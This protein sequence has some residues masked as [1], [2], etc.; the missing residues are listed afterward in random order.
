MPYHPHTSGQVEISNW[1]I[2]DIFA[3][4]VNASRKYW[5]RKLDDALWAY[6]TAFK[7]P[8]GMLPYQLVYGKACHL[9]IEIDQ[10]ALWVLKRL[11]LNWNEV[12]NMILG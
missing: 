12:E 10:K 4:T 3:K 6:R 1:E 7:T 9:P 11:N 8:I 5:S 2:K